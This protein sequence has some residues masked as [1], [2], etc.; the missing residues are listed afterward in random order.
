MGIV[1]TRIDD[2]LIHGQVTVAWARVLNVN[3][4]VVISDSAAKN[5]IQQQLLK[6]S[7]PP[8]VAVDILTVDEAA[9]RIM[10]NSFDKD[11][12]LLI[13]DSPKSLLRLIQQGVKLEVVN[14]GNLG[15]GGKPG[16]RKIT[17]SI[18][19]TPEDELILKELLKMGIKITV[20]MMPMDKEEDL[21][22]YIKP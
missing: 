10:S 19:I 4:I 20:R 21:T 8:N 16:A 9:K 18:Y 17:K 3:R 11:K 2:R 12:V 14:L 6:M 1:H 15:G 5:P 13:V 7:A 22:A